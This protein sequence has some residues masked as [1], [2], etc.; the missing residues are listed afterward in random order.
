MGRH[1]D[2][3]TA[4]L[5]ARRRGLRHRLAGKNGREAGQK[6]KAKRADHE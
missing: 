2:T 5:G 6:H 3:G 1:I 4:F